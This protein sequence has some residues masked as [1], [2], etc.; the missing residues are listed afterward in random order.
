MYTHDRSGYEV[1]LLEFFWWTR[2]VGLSS[3]C[4]TFAVVSHRN[5]QTDLLM[6]GD[7]PVEYDETTI[8]SQM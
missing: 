6:I 2:A 3:V 1:A 4:N 5:I 7:Q 8:D